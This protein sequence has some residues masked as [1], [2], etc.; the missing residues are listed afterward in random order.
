MKYRISKFLNPMGAVYLL[1]RWRI[2]SDE[3]MAAG[4]G[5]SL[6]VGVHGAAQESI[7]VQ[8]YTYENGVV[9]LVDNSLSEGS[10]F[11]PAYY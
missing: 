7:Q 10:W 5:T 2:A 11:A 4:S 8:R 3:G 6:R 9:F 1:R